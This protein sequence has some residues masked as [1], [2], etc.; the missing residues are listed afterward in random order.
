[1]PFRR[2]QKIRS[3]LRRVWSIRQTSTRGCFFT[4]PLLSRHPVVSTHPLPDE[5][6]LAGHGCN[7]P[8]LGWKF[9]RRSGS[10]RCRQRCR[11]QRWIT[12]IHCVRM[13][14]GA[15]MR[16]FSQYHWR[17]HA[18][19][20]V[21]EIEARGFQYCAQG[22]A[23]SCSRKHSRSC[24]QGSGMRSR[25]VGNRCLPHQGRRTRCRS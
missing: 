19:Y 5:P 25:Y 8:G 10:A 9:A 15:Q 21:E 1:M 22:S 3:V 23:L 2:K 11:R 6:F 17:I 16:T 13:D 20:A 4:H 14:V 18:A 7:P 12:R 24:T